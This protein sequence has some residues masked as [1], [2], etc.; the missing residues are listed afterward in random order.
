MTVNSSNNNNNAQRN[1]NNMYLANIRCG[2]IL[3]QRLVMAWQRVVVNGHLTS[4]K[5]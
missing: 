4:V 3:L 1:N 5:R 2:V